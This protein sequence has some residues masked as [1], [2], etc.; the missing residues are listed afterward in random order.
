MIINILSFIKGILTLA[1]PVVQ[2]LK[3][4]WIKTLML[5]VRNN[6]C[7]LYRLWLIFFLLMQ[8]FEPVKSIYQPSF[9]FCIKRF[10]KSCKCMCVFTVRNLSR[11]YLSYCNFSLS[12]C[13]FIIFLITMWYWIKIELN[14]VFLQPCTH[15]CMW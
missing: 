6:N 7:T 5:K 11:I 9:M 2:P 8:F 12:T 15:T 3:L 10:S 1:N 13:T 4:L 14:C